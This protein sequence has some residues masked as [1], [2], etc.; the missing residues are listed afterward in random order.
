M[1]AALLSS[2]PIHADDDGGDRGRAAVINLSHDLVELG[3]ASGNLRPDSPAT[4]ARPLFQAAL[5]YAQGHAV[6]LLTVDRGDYYFLTPQ[7][8]QDFLRVSSLSNL[9]VDLV[10]STIHFATGLLRGFAIVDCSN[11]TLTRFRTEY[12][13][14]PYTQVRLTYADPLRRSL[15]YA[16]LPGWADP[17]AFNALAAPDPN[18]GPVEFWAMAFRGGDI[19][20]GTSRMHVAQPIAS[21]VLELVQDNTPWTQSATLATL[22][23][24]DTVVLAARG[25]FGPVTVV[26]GDHVTISEATVQGSSAIA[27]LFISSSHSV[28]D[29]VG[30]MPRRPADLIASNA[31]GIHFTSAGPD[32]HIRRSVVTRTMD[33]AMAIDSRD[34]ATVVSQT[35]PRQ[36]KADRT[37]FLRFPNGTA[38]TF[39]DP[40]SAAES[41]SATI[42]EQTPPDSPAPVFNG[43]VVLTFD[44]DLPAITPGSGIALAEASARGAGSSIEDNVARDIVFGRGIWIAGAEDVRVERN[45]V[46]HTSSGGIAVAQNTT[47]YPTPAAHDI[48]IRDN[49][50]RGSLGPMA[51]GSGTQIAVGAIMVASTNNKNQFSASA[52]NT[53]IA[54]ER[55]R[56]LDSG[57]TGIW[58]GELGGGTISG[59]VIIGWD[60]HPELPLFG[61]NPATR[62]Q[63]L[64]DFAQAL[65][66][67]NSASVATSGNVTRMDTGADAD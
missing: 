17:V 36:L 54:I 26:R 51:S 4:D 34:L 18:T 21:G 30:V 59:N 50:V 67:R 65:V 49:V 12:I 29:R 27:V 53:D 58:V 43:E 55:N 22:D 7:D 63:L 33:D 32:N 23:P 38:I 14:P 52:A 46:G 56:V 2:A 31:D 47:S 16:T 28:A 24:G 15:A 13:T 11:V 40:V 3:I 60:R 44:R 41:A 10:D 48:V 45:A 9:T 6:H 5:A 39:V 20:P 25:G 42:V 1:L 61:V 64:Q 19:V 57:R 8:P 62:A 66:V 35:G 37:A